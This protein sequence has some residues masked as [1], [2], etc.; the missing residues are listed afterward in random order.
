VL[1]FNEASAPDIAP[2][3]R[4]AKRLARGLMARSDRLF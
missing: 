1:D 4:L 3:N 2:E